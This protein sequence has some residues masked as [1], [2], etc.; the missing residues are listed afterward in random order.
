MAG[1]DQVS[2]FQALPPSLIVFARLPIQ[3]EVKTRIAHELGAVATLD[4]YRKL[5]YGSVEQALSVAALWKAPVT[6]EWH[7]AGAMGALAVEDVAIVESLKG[8]DVVF[9][10]QRGADL[11]ERMLNSLFASTAPSVL[12]GSD[13]PGLDAGVLHQALLAIKGAGKTLVFNPT[14]D[15]GYCLIGRSQ[16][17]QSQ[18]VAQL[19]DQIPWSTAEVMKQTLERLM[20]VR[21]SDQ[22]L[23]WQILAP[24]ADIDE[25]QQAR[26]YL[27]L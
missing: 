9:V 6:L 2:G 5:V 21:L 14:E 18:L 4:L 23:S 15:G 3:G 26:A 24:L 12:F 1:T 27:K 8:K 19:F 11:G 17:V 10:E 13:I 25:P 20:K 16:T 7:Y 22:T